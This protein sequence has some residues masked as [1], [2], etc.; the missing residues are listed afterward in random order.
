MNKK[1]I[2]IMIAII[3]GAVLICAGVAI[4]V[5]M[6]N[7]DHVL[8][9]T[10]PSAAVS[11]SEV[12]GSVTGDITGDP[13]TA[14]TTNPGAVETDS[15]GETVTPANTDA[16]NATDSNTGNTTQTTPTESSD[17]DALPVLPVDGGDPDDT[18][19][20]YDPDKDRDNGNSGNSGDN[21][22]GDSGN[23]GDNGGSTEPSESVI[24]LPFI[25]AE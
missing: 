7:K 4:G 13:D 11:S 2:I 21:G 22:N 9:S 10:D 20:E 23:T 12:T 6:Y 18:G 5:K 15:N 16:T 14:V 24:E 25:P 1:Q 19:H 8:V 3:A 17:K